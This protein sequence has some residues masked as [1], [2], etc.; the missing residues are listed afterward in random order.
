MWTVV[1]AAVVVAYAT[2]FCVCVCE[3]VHV[4]DCLL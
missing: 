1:E 2:T 3:L 4:F